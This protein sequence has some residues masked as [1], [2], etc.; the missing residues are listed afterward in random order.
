MNR[1]FG[2]YI[3][4]KEE[5]DEVADSYKDYI[6]SFKATK[7]T[8]ELC[9]FTATKFMEEYKKKKE[10]P[11]YECNFDVCS[12]ISILQGQLKIVDDHLS[13][14]MNNIENFGRPC[15]GR[16]VKDDS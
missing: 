14:I 16:K 5:I 15:N 6:S 2:Q 10:D 9:L 4:S 3:I 11:D 7:D 12:S 13:N 1:I 8:I